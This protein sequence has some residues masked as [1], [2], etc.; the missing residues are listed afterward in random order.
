MRPISAPTFRHEQRCVRTILAFVACLGAGAHVSAQTGGDDAPRVSRTETPVSAE[1]IQ[2]HGERGA[3]LIIVDQFEPTALAGQAPSQVTPDEPFQD[4]LLFD[5]F[6]IT[7]PWQVDQLI[8]Y[9]NEAGD[10]GCN[11]NVVGQIWSGRPGDGG[12]IVL[13]GPGVQIGNDLVINFGAQ[14]LPPGTYLVNAHVIRPLANPCPGGQWFAQ[15][16]TLGSASEAG[17]WQPNA[18][19]DIGKITDVALV[20]HP[21]LDMMLQLFGFLADFQDCNGNLID[22][23]IDIAAFESFDTNGNGV[24]DECERDGLGGNPPDF[25]LDGIPDIDDPQ[26]TVYHVEPG[27]AVTSALCAQ[28]S[29]PETEVHQAASL[30]EHGALTLQFPTSP[31][32]HLYVN[33]EVNGTWAVQNQVTYTEESPNLAPTQSETYSIDL[34]NPRGA[35]VTGVGVRW[36]VDPIGLSTLPPG[37]GPVIPVTEATYRVGGNPAPPGPKPPVPLSEG[38]P[39]APAPA[40]EEVKTT[41]E[42]GLFTVSDLKWSFERNSCG[43]NSVGGSFAWL[44]EEYMLMLPPEFDT[45]DELVQRFR[46]MM[47]TLVG[48]WTTD[49]QMKAAKEGFIRKHKLPLTVESGNV[50][51]ANRLDTLTTPEAIQNELKKGQDVEILFGWW[52]K[53]GPGMPPTWKRHGGHFVAIKKVVKC[54]KNGMTTWKITFVHDSRQTEC[55]GIE[56]V[57]VEAGSQSLDLDRDGTDES[58]WVLDAA[59]LNAAG[60]TPVLESFVAESPTHAHLAKKVKALIQEFNA[61]LAAYKV[62]GFDL[63]EAEELR[64]RLDEIRRYARRALEIAKAMGADPDVIDAWERAIQSCDEGI[65]KLE[66][67]I[68]ELESGSRAVLPDDVVLV[69]EIEGDSIENADV[70]AIEAGFPTDSDFDDVP[71]A[72]DNAPFDANPDQADQDNNSIADVLELSALND[73]NDNGVMD[74]YEVTL[75]AIVAYDIDGLPIMGF[76]FDEDTSGLPDQCEVAPPNECL[77]DL[78]G[79]FDTD[80]LDFA[81]FASNFGSPVTPGGSGGDYDLDGFVTVLDFAIFLSEFGCTP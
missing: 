47:N 51:V 65:R 61:L 72:T 8:V 68:A 15:L 6:T 44:A 60:W 21:P 35:P 79:D 81:I 32:I 31:G 49:V 59:P 40:P 55:G 11:Q 50:G 39:V 73:C 57:T 7:R 29:F 3:P 62:D 58:A 74:V 38:G 34:G 77:T 19:G 64:D 13:Q 37:T 2:R 66:A 24:P 56:C 28:L 70:P 43:P 4:T 14:L 41:V 69:L 48:R 42:N 16:R 78:D 52:K 27:A 45:V 1:E 67:R 33:I 63:S 54:V 30:T 26:P 23:F 18:P 9:G 76:P 10:P 71:D 5:E 20:N 17:L 25:D 75:G 46:V 80:V 22:D 53:D 36:W 12:A